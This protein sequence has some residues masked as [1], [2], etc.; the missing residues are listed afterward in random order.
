MMLKK[1]FVLTNPLNHEGGVV[2]YYNLFF[3]H[4]KSDVISL[5]HGVIGSRAYLFYFPILKRILYPI[6]LIY[7]MIMFT[8]RLIFDRS[9]KIVQVS[10]SLIPVPLLRD[11]LLVIISKLLGKKVVVF[12]RGWKLP[13]YNRI[14][15]SDFLRRIFNFVFQNDTLQIVLS[16]SFKEDL[17]NLNFNKEVEIVVTTTAINKEEIK[18]NERNISNRII[19]VLFLGRIQD[20]KGIEELIDAIII[21]KE[22]KQLENFNFTIAGH[23][24]KTGYKNKLIEKLKQNDISSDI[25]S[26]PGRIKGKDKFELYAKHNVYV[27]ASYTE[28]CPNSLLEALA[29]GLFCITTNVGALSDLIIP[30]ENGLFVKVKSSEDIVG[31]LMYCMENKDY[32]KNRLVNSE[33]YSN[34]FDIHNITNL[35]ETKYI[36]LIEKR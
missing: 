3:Q 17:I 20:I 4:F 16:S 9:I 1:V 2:N 29:S 8:L 35:F 15:K 13:T 7:D 28:G 25:V 6:Y 24:N 36:E 14:A 10:P 23:E 19:R 21:L 27:L 34:K 30:E 32:N 22:R 12:Y 18:K 11:G 31:A 33:Y 5:E 26:F